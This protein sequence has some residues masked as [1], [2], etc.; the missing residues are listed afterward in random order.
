M[1]L[2]S[3]LARKAGSSLQGELLLSKCQLPPA[4]RGGVDFVR[5]IEARIDSDLGMV[6]LN[7]FFYEELEREVRD[8]NFIQRY[9]IYVQNAFMACAVG[10]GRDGY[11]VDAS[12][13][14]E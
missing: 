14:A 4:H 10:V 13:D 7:V 12:K 6:G 11:I 9:R 3:I 2:R 8:L 1:N 5:K